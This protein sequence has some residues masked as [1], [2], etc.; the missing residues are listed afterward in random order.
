MFSWTKRNDTKRSDRSN[1]KL[2]ALKKNTGIKTK[3]NNGAKK[4]VTFSNKTRVRNQYESVNPETGEHQVNLNEYNANASKNDEMPGY[5]MASPKFVP[6]SKSSLVQATSQINNSGWTRSIGSVGPNVH[7]N[8][9]AAFRSKI[10]MK[11][12]Y[13]NAWVNAEAKLED[14]YKLKD[15]AIDL[16]IANYNKGMA[17]LEADFLERSGVQAPTVL[18]KMIDAE[19]EKRLKTHDASELAIMKYEME[20]EARQQLIKVPFDIRIEFENRAVGLRKKLEKN[21]VS[22]DLAVRSAMN[23]VPSGKPYNKR[24]K[25]TLKNRLSTAHVIASMAPPNAVAVTPKKKKIGFF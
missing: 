19:V 16:A 20:M 5:S 17:E 9:P 10:F 22:A 3:R 18:E 25:R 14:A 7:V 21:T 1:T 8:R 15:G 2:S 12:R 11:N 6:H 13:G 23:T 24:A 4:G